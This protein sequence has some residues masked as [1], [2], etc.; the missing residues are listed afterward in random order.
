LSF[1]L[2]GFF[3]F[4][5]GLLLFILPILGKCKKYHALQKQNSTSDEKSNNSNVSPPTA[6]LRTKFLH[7]LQTRLQEISAEMPNNKKK[8]LMDCF[9]KEKDLINEGVSV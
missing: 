7:P 5:S 4:A 8:R 1:Y 3:V 6:Y 2:A 9:G